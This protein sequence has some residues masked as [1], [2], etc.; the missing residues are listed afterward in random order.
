[1]PL[2]ESVDGRQLGA[3]AFA[4]LRAVS[5]LCKV[6]LVTVGSICA[7]IFASLIITIIQFQLR[8]SEAR[9]QNAS[10]T[11]ESVQLIADYQDNIANHYKQMR[12]QADLLNGLR[13]DYQSK[14]NTT[15]QLI[16]NLCTA[17]NP[18]SA[19]QCASRLESL[20]NNNNSQVDS[21]IADL[22]PEGADRLKNGPFSTYVENL[23]QIITSGTLQEAQTKLFN[24]Q[25]FVQSECQTLSRY[26]SDR[27]GTSLLGVSPELRMTIVVQCVAG[28]IGDQ[29]A[30]QTAALPVN[31]VNS[32]ATPGD[33]G[34]SK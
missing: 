20:I 29:A 26:I 2:V 6:L 19:D 33:G 17:L 4:A 27:V 16:T 21:A 13:T 34:Q 15:T 31:A 32:T 7:V 9:T 14:L 30:A 18:Q 24:T 23:K 8:L 28:S 5:A 22:S 12:R 25:N 1:M 10:I 11:L 3:R